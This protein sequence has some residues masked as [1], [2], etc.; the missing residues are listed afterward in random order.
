MYNTF[1]ILSKSLIIVNGVTRVL[2]RN[3]L[4]TQSS[5]WHVQNSRDDNAVRSHALVKNFNHND[6]KKYLFSLVI[7]WST[8]NAGGLGSMPGQGTISHL[9]HLRVHKLQLKL[10]LAATISWCSQINKNRTINAAQTTPH[11]SFSLCLTFLTHICLL[12]GLCIR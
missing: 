1:K 4:K 2:K 8:A 7:W 6:F 11:L 5:R 12:G 3:S 10:P 9:L